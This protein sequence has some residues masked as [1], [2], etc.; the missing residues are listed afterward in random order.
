MRPSGRRACWRILTRQIG[1]YE[2]PVA[3]QQSFST[4]DCRS[5]M[6]LAVCA[7]FRNEAPY[8]REWIEFHRIVGVEHF[9]LY[10]NRSDDDWQNVLRPFIE[11]GVVEVTEWPMVPPCQMQAYQHF[12]DRHKGQRDWVAILDCDEFLFSSCY[13]KI[14]DVLTQVPKWWG[15]LA[16]NWLCF[17]ASGRETQSPEPVIERFTCRPADD[18]GPNVHIKSILRMDQVESAGGNP[19][20]FHVRG[21]TFDENGEKIHGPFT[22][23]PNHRLLRIHHYH[24]KSRQEYLERIARGKADGA[25]PRD[26]SEFE[27]YQA[28]E[29]DDRT[30]WQFLPALKRRLSIAP[31]AP[32][33][34][35]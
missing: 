21:G 18:F 24:T 8:L 2:Q 5:A 14:S 33:C 25:P 23:R 17:G 32:Y 3:E 4:F 26:P 12:I 20:S 28:A 13:P 22:S 19:H 9:Y 11:E 27:Q 16:V 10:Q 15:A 6:P 30:I 29:V 7:I 34:V 31:P 1:D 35:R